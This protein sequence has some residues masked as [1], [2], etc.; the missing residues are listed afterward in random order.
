MLPRHFVG[1]V[2]SSPF[3]NQL[4][5]S[6]SELFAD[7]RFHFW[8]IAAMAVLV[9]FSKL[10]IGDLGGYDDAVYAHEGKQMLSTG[11]WW[12]VYLNGQLDFDKPPLFVWLEAISMWIFGVT[13][14]AARFP[15]ARQRGVVE[16]IRQACPRKA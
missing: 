1:G 15:S 13:D 7:R 9:L 4:R 10:H 2:R 11:Q 12:S 3:A 14:F 8:L 16:G 5:F 6:L